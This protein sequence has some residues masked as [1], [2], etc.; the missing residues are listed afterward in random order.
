MRWPVSS[1]MAFRRAGDGR[2]GALAEVLRR[3]NT[4]AALAEDDFSLAAEIVRHGVTHL[5]CT[6]SM[7]RMLVGDEEARGVL[8]RLRHIL[9][10]GEALP[11]ALVSDLAKA[12]K[13]P[14]HNMYGPT[15]TTIWSTTAIATPGEA[16]AGIGGPVANTQVY[17]LDGDLNPVPVGVEGELWIGGEGVTRGIGGATT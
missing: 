9:I 8:S 10:G 11:G 15:E 12:T 6:P 7:A 14:V 1:T 13:A 17:V 4:G 3:S 16:V 2:A 5:Q